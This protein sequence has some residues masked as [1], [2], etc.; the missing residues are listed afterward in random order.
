MC[1]LNLNTHVCI[2]SAIL[3]NQS[4]NI[5]NMGP[6]HALLLTVYFIALMVHVSSVFIF[7]II[8]FI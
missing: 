4:V 6:H 8:L 3:Q 1:I 5:L 7:I 2:L